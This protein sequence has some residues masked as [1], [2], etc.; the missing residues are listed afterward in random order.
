MPINEGSIIR[1]RLNSVLKR[2][3]ILV[4]GLMSVFAGDQP[5]WGQAWSRN[6]VSEERGLPA[7]FNPATGENVKW[8][9]KLGTESHST[10][11]V[12]GGHVYIGTNNG[13]PRN[14][15][16]KGDR[17]VLM[18]FDERDGSFLWQL[19]VPKLSEDPY[20]DWPNSGWSSEVTVEGDRVYTVSN[21]G[22]VLCLDPQG[23]ANGNQ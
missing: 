16:H 13:E 9:A 2:L 22:E 19:V 18:C 12:A 14:P 5:Q 8:R 6:M 17:G 1:S 23:L 11:V 21:R 7:E 10:P 3:I 20:Y 4:S 15:E